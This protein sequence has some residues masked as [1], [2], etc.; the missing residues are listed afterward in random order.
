M[1]D[2]DRNPSARWGQGATRIGRA[3]IDQGLR[4]YMLGVYNNMVVGLALTGAVA[5]GVHML[6]V[7]TDPALGVPVGRH[8]MLTSFGVT[9]YT[10]PL[11]WVMM[12][13]PLAFVFF[14]S[15]RIN[16]MS[17]STARGVFL[18]FVHHPARLYRN[19]GCERLLCDRGGLRRLEPLWLHNAA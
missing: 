9:L 5:L 16:Q 11:K 7:T 4:S 3:E 8:L 18:A 13:A 19:I 15:F 6:A 12:L 1:S 14:F 17:A 2:Y 10:S